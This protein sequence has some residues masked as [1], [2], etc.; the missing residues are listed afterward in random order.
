MMQI[1]KTVNVPSRPIK[2]CLTAALCAALPV[3][4]L[5][6]TATPAQAWKPTSHVGLAELALRDALADGRVTID[7]LNP[8]TGKLKQRRSYKVDPT[9]LRVLRSNRSQY[10]AGILGPDAYPDILTGQQVIHPEANGS[11]GS[12][13]W[14]QHV[15]S[16]GQRS[17]SSAI[18]A[19]SLGYLTHAAGDMFAHT[20]VNHFTGG[21][22]TVTPPTNAAKHM[23]LEGYMDQHAPK[24]F[25]SASIRGV[26]R[27]IYTT[28]IDAKPG[29]HLDRVLLRRGGAG[30]KAS[31][32]RI[33]STLKTSLQKDIKGY[34]AKKRRYDQRYRAKMKQA[35]ACKTFDF[36][37]SRVALTAQAGKIKAAK[38]VYMVKNGPVVTYK[39]AWVKDIDRGLKILPSV[40]HKVAKAL[41]FNPQKKADVDLAERLV[42]NYARD[43][44]LS[45]SGSPDAL[46]KV[47]KFTGKASDIISRAIPSAIKQPIRQIKANAYNAVI[48]AATG[49]SKAQLKAYMTNPKQNFDRLM[50]R[51]PGKRVNRKTF[52]RVYMK[53]DRSN[54]NY[55]PK[56]FAAA[57]NTVTMTK[58]MMLNRTEVNRLMRD[59]G[60]KRRLRSSN[61]MLGYIRSL[62]GGNEQKR[63]V[64]GENCTIY[65]SVFKRQAGENF[66]R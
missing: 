10:R 21:D 18:K 53:L 57:H 43:H 13:A 42:K 2:Y 29:S 25:Y 41:F 14:M 5:G 51:G 63:M 49:M 65:R 15:W 64:L 8:R 33:Y 61:I 27:F 59:L 3:C 11:G 39:E 23:L 54:T 35:R 58:L 4:T 62:D 38:G 28:F 22:F 17:S 9:I 24:P 55:D 48:K 60:G 47:I 37:C 26:E 7:I 6:L 30:T 45:M 16:Q 66:C 32:P 44:L 56:K 34:Y 12:N 20:F 50:P 31:I 52:D 1:D 40:S 46:G 36:S 19:F